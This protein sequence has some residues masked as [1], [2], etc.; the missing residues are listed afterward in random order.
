MG[1]KHITVSK[2]RREY[3][4]LIAL[5]DIEVSTR[6][7]KARNMRTLCAEIGK[8]QLRKIRPAHIARAVR[9]IWETGHH[10][11]ARRVLVTARDMFSEAVSAGYIDS[12]PAVFVDP[13]PYR[14]RRARLSLRHWRQ[15]QAVLAVANVPWRRVLAVL[16]LA[17]GQRRSDLARMRFDDVW[18]GYLHVE[19]VKTGARIALPLDL[20]LRAIGATLHD[21]IEQCRQYDPPGETLLR[22]RSG[23]GLSVSSLTKAFKV[24]FD[25]AV[26]WDRADHTAPSL[27]EIRSLAARLYGAQGVDTQTLLGHKNRATTAIY[28]DDRGLSREEGHWRKLKLPAQRCRQ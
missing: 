1:K 7:E 11:R 14:V 19:Q 21:V 20:H 10:S 5:R 8:R 17:T 2:L 3:L 18:G 9:A 15:T 22:K 27:A 12:N 13:L 4:R 28:H 25:A 6:A 23:A 16:A 24:A 26:L